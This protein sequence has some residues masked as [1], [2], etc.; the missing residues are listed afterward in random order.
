MARAQRNVRKEGYA[1]PYWNGYYNRGWYYD[2]DYRLAQRIAG[3]TMTEWEE[4]KRHDRER[5]LTMALVIIGVMAV[6]FSLTRAWM[7]QAMLR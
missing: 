3:L 7:L 1:Q 2:R 4:R 5:A 6:T